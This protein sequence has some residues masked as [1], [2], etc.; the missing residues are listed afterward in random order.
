MLFS[1]VYLMT[2]FPEAKTLVYGEPGFEQKVANLRDYDFVFAP[3][4][5][6]PLMPKPKIDLAIN[7]VSFQEMTT[8]QVDSYAR[9][10]KHFGCRRIYSLNKDR[11]KHNDELTTVSEVLGRYYNLNLI[12]VCD[13]QYT[14]LAAAGK[15][16]GE[17]GVLDYR[18]YF[19]NF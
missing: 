11:S 8:D 3:H 5:Y 2:L 14:Q 7:M 16:P 19:G 1:A 9:T 10:L 6:F 17:L 15:P 4:Y 13:L 12:K 18:H